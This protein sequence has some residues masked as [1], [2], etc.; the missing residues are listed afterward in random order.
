[1]SV[2]TEA[3][4]PAP[5]QRHN[6]AWV[7][8]SWALLLCALVMAAAMLV[9]GEYRSSASSLESAI[10]AGRVDAVQVEGGNRV[11]RGV[12]GGAIVQWREGLVARYAETQRPIDL[13]GVDVAYRDLSSFTTFKSW[14]VPGWVVPL[15]VLLFIVPLAFI[16]G[17]P[18]PSRATRWAW[19]W[20]V[21]TAWPLGVAAFLV[22]SG[23]L[24]VLPPR[25]P[26][27]RLT[28]GWAF[29]LSFVL[30]GALTM[31]AAAILGPLG[32]V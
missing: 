13:S 25:R 5:P 31:A 24:G 1:V 10:A 20:L 7:G 27:R 23:R 14:R 28:G 15:G 19:F 2:E 11:D 12:R 22:L 26:G 4:A 17:G 9:G 18:Q 29:L 6:L 21:W 32:L 16:I 30:G 3:E 8:A